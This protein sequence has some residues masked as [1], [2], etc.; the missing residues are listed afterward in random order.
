MIFSYVPRAVTSHAS[1]SGTHRESRGSV[2]PRLLSHI[3]FLTSYILR[4]RMGTIIVL[5]LEA[6]LYP[7]NI[8]V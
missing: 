3:Y 6:Y 8:I 7:N 4:V 5:D 2:M 1:H